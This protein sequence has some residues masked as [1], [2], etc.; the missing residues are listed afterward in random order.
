[1]ESHASVAMVH[2][3]GVF[4]SIWLCSYSEF[5]KPSD[6]YSLDHEFADGSISGEG[7]VRIPMTSETVD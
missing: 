4:L 2:N 7:F 5:F 3:E 1:M 6:I